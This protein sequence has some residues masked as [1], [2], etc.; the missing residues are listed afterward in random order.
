MNLLAEHRLPNHVVLSKE[1][2]V[3]LGKSKPSRKRLTNAI[4]ERVK[5]SLMLSRPSVRPKNK[6]ES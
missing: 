1:L 2:G 5:Q 4:L 6:D 3:P